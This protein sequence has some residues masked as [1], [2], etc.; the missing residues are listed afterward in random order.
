[1]EK[2]QMDDLLERKIKDRLAQNAP[3]PDIVDKKWKRLI[4]KSGNCKGQGNESCLSLLNSVQLQRFWR[5]L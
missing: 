1:M 4:M 3:E 5:L 2:K